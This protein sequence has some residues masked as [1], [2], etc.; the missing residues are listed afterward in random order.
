MILDVRLRAVLRLAFI[1]EFNVFVKAATCRPISWIC[2]GQ[3]RSFNAL[4][5]LSRFQVDLA[6]WIHLISILSIWNSFLLI[7]L[8]TCRS[9]V[10][11]FLAC[12]DGRSDIH[13]PVGYNLLM[14]SLSHIS[15]LFRPI[16]ALHI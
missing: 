1:V 3:S 5:Y 9:V 14:V 4:N 16:S 11:V 15:G 7:H 12:I 6:K 13:L 8:L 2:R 10:H